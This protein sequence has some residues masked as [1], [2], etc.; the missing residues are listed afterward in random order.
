MR[1][2]PGAPLS[3]ALFLSGT[4]LVLA[5]GTAY[6][7]TSATAASSTSAA[8]SSG[9]KPVPVPSGAGAVDTS[10][11]DHVIGHGTPGSCTSRKVLRAVA[12]GGV[13]TFRCGPNPVVIRLHHTAKVVN[14]S[15]RVVLDGGGLVTLSGAGKR[16]ILW[17]NACDPRQVRLK[18]CQDSSH[19]LLVVQHI[20]LAHG[21]SSGNEYF[22]GGGG[23]IFSYGGRLRIVDSTFISNRCDRTGADLGGGA[24]RARFQY[25]NEPVYVVDSTFVGGRCS[26]GAALSSLNVSWVIL[27]SMFHG[28]RAIGHGANPARP[29]TPGG[30]SGGAIYTDGEDYTVSIAGTVMRRNQA[31]EGGGAIFYVS[32]DRTGHLH[33][34][35]STLKNNVSGRFETRP[36]IFYEGNGPMDL[37]HSIVR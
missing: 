12:K 9:A 20:T 37:S 22:N 18:N 2:P 1:R 26:N 23:A 16:R 21:N 19:P 14:T 8:I 25:H 29:G 35:W 5:L 7:G 10:N 32:N 6:A 13:I 36:G 17:E 27:N 33:V 15:R 11:P 34:N 31:N 4:A 28:N 24:V 3:R 30:G